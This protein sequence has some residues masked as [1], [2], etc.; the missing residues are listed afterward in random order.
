MPQGITPAMLYAL[1]GVAIVSAIM[2]TFARKDQFSLVLWFVLVLGGT[3]SA[4][5]TTADVAYPR[6]TGPAAEAP[7]WT[8]HVSTVKVPVVG[9]SHRR[10]P[11]KITMSDGAVV[12][13]PDGEVFVPGQ[14]IGYSCGD[15]ECIIS[16]EQTSTIVPG[17]GL[18]WFWVYWPLMVA[19]IALPLIVFLRS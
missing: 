19:L 14:T 13:V 18:I 1:L 12:T 8:H 10:G 7:G 9:D 2:T 3:L 15:R 16:T 5:A 6:W 4:A 17:P 11:G